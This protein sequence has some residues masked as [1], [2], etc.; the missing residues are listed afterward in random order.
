MRP[1]FAGVLDTHGQTVLPVLPRGGAQMRASIFCSCVT[2]ELRA[3]VTGLRR[4]ESAVLSPS[5][6]RGCSSGVRD[7]L[8][9][10][11][12]GW[13]V[14]LFTHFRRF[15]RLTLTVVLFVSGEKNDGGSYSFHAPCPATSDCIKK[16]DAEAARTSKTSFSCRAIHPLSSQNVLAARMQDAGRCASPGA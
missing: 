5:S 2:R 16:F 9:T 1:V 4:L 7:N 6:F 15:A 10:F 12:S 14:A 11:V 13:W 8:V 3:A